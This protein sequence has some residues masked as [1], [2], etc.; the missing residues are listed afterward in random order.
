VADG[1]HSRELDHLVVFLA[2]VV[3]VLTA[4]PR[5]GRALRAHWLDVAIVVLTMPIL[6]AALSALRGLRLARLLRFLRIVAVLARALQAERKLSS[7]AVFRFTGLV[8]VL[9]VV[10]AGA[11]ES[12]V[13]H[14]DF[15]S[16]W[17]G[18]WWAT[19]TV[20]TVG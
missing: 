4:A 18:V 17:D 15:K 14:G 19:V 5:K 2:E 3:F 13:D 12:L 1:R 10:V 11:A 8:T 20:T 16:T 9:I 6:G 7:G